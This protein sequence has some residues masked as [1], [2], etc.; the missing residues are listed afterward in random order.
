MMWIASLWSS[1][2]FG[3]P[4]QGVLRHVEHLTNADRLVLRSGLAAVRDEERLHEFARHRGVE[5]S[6]AIAP[7]AELDDA[8]LLVERDVGERAS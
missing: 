5:E 3:G 4:L 1:K 6:R 7:V 8:A 2:V